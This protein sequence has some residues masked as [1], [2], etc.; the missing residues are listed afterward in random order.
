MNPGDFNNLKKI[1]GRIIP[2]LF[3]EEEEESGNIH[4]AGE[5]IIEPSLSYQFMYDPE[6]QP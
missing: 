4:F 5:I 6:E 1:E 2:K 3:L